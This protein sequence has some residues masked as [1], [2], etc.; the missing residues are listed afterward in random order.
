M[1]ET[2]DWI[3]NVGG[4]AT[5]IS[6]TSNRALEDELNNQLE[7]ISNNLFRNFNRKNFIMTDTTL[8]ELVF[9]YSLNGAYVVNNDGGKPFLAHSVNLKRWQ[10]LSAINPELTK[11]EFYSKVRIKGLADGR[12]VN[13]VWISPYT[14]LSNGEYAK[15]SV[16]YDK[17]QNIYLITVVSGIEP[18]QAI[19]STNSNKMIEDILGS[20]QSIEEAAVVNIHD[21]ISNQTES[22]NEENNNNRATVYGRYT[23]ADK[24]DE[25]YLI[26]L[27]KY[28]KSIT[29]P[30]KHG[31]NEWTKAYLPINDDQAAIV[32]FNDY[33]KK[34]LTRIVT[35]LS[36]IS[37]VLAIVAI[38]FYVFILVQMRLKPIK[39][40]EG[41]LTNVAEG[42]F[43]G[44]VYIKEGNELDS[45]GDIIDDMTL[46]MK[47][48]IEKLNQAAAEDVRSTEQVYRDNIESLMV[49][50]DSSRHDMRNHVNVLH[51][52]ITDEKYNEARSYMEE[53][54]KDLKE[55]DLPIQTKNL[56]V[57]T[58]IRTKV[59][60][61]E[62]DKIDFEAEI[63]NDLFDLTK[64]TDL[65]KILSNLIDNAMEAVM[66]C[67]EGNRRVHVSLTKKYQSYYEIVVTNNGPKIEE[68]LLEK[69]F[70]R[71]FS[72]KAPKKSSQSAERGSGLAIIKDIVRNYNGEFNCKSTDEQTVFSV[73]LDVR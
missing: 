18:Y 9:N 62:T 55:I 49:S 36:I 16:A 66:A 15:Y 21:F 71:G 53:V 45:L 48:M 58:L 34:D 35:W 63:D 69:I 56:Q 2:L 64:Q 51:G 73:M 7:T 14:Q 32:I 50:I 37:N 8:T 28:K 1:K 24:S 39:R 43:S 59:K 57:G 41:H 72:T 33:S 26:A 12:F 31:A 40:L 20:S 30:F 65:V 3:A 67:P 54:Y 46:R 38:S 25:D 11:S 70:E 5:N 13:E 22:T 68:D 60:L 10:D 52:L 23:F 29:V 44:R 61:A 6:E 19:N 17:L 27:L 47:S 42:D 4:L